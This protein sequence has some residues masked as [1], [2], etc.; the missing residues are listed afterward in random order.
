M[1]C[2]HTSLLIYYNLFCAQLPVELHRKGLLVI[3]GTHI[4]M[5]LMTPPKSMPVQQVPLEDN[6]VLVSGLSSNCNVDDLNT[7]FTREKTHSEIERVIIGL[8][9]G[10]AMFQFTYSPGKQV[11]AMVIQNVIS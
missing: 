11:D 4:Q 9:P 8:H 6:I 10:I 3:E 1:L 2:R 7:F 5:K